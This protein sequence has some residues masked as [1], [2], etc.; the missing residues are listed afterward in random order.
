MEANVRSVQH[1]VAVGTYY[2]ER[3]GSGNKMSIDMA[4]DFQKFVRYLLFPSTQK[5]R[6]FCSSE[7]SGYLYHTTQRHILKGGILHSYCSENTKFQIYKKN[8][9]YFNYFVEC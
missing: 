7:M 1:N 4:K 8:V 5:M 2:K 9:E 3:L 6:T